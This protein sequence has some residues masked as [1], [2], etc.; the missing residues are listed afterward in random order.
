MLVG[1]VNNDGDRRRAKRLLANNW[2]A[3]VRPDTRKYRER[4]LP[5]SLEIALSQG[6]KAAANRRARHFATCPEARVML[7]EQAEELLACGRF[8]Y[9]QLTLIQA[10]TLWALPDDPSYIAARN[11][12]GASA[13]PRRRVDQWLSTAGTRTEAEH[14]RLLQQRASPRRRV[15]G[16]S[17][18][19]GRNASIERSWLHPFVREAADL[20]VHALE[21]GHPERFLWIDETG[22]ISKVGSHPS[23]P[24]QPRIHNLWIPPS[25]GWTALERR[26]QQLV[27]DV[28][29][30]LNLSDR[31]ETDEHERHLDRANRRDL[32]PCL[33]GDRTTMQPNLSGSTRPSVVGGL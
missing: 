20:A 3:W 10:L 8:W 27:A 25:T 1:S 12:G 26:A 31:R 5:L 30:L 32:P 13:A 16:R 4:P 19:N 2:L 18:R 15:D 33:I 29:L 6:F 14:N 9:T 22:V 11:R 28:L 21:S 24:A 17:S 7:I 23:D